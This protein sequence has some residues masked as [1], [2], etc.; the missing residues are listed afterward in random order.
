[1]EVNLSEV[2]FKMPLPSPSP[3]THSPPT[4]LPSNSAQPASGSGS[5]GRDERGGEGG[6]G[7]GAW[8]R[9]VGLEVLEAC[10][11]QM[12]YLPYFAAS[13]MCNTAGLSDSSTAASSAASTSRP[14]TSTAS[15]SADSL[16]NN[17]IFPSV[18]SATNVASPSSSSTTPTHTSVSSASLTSRAWRTTGASKTRVASTR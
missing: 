4:I 10:A 17:R 2:R 3:T 5:G 7:G 11:S 13:P 14:C 1:M 12:M 9:V 6:K 16:E 15:A 18:A 8:L